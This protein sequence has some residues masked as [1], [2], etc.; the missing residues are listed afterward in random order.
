[1]NEKH[2]V[3]WV[4]EHFVQRSH[5]GDKS[6]Y[7]FQTQSLVEGFISMLITKLIVNS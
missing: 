1:M 6:V 4:A 7:Y 3:D 5:T 2:T